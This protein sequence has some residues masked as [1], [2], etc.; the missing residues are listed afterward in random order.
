MSLTDE[1][2]VAQILTELS[3]LLADNE[4]IANYKKIKA[5]VDKNQSL[6]ELEEEIEAAQQAAVQFAHYG[7]PEAEQAAIKEADALTQKMNQHPQV[8]AYRAALYE[9]NDLLHHLT[10]MIQKEVNQ[11]LEEEQLDASKN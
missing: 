8:V 1:P 6:K 2:A 5:R 3:A 9:A 4:T 11:A 7:K 10:A